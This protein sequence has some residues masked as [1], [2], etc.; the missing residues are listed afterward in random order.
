MNLRKPLILLAIAAIT[1]LAICHYWKPIPYN[2]KLVRIQAEQLLGPIDERITREPLEIQAVL[3]DYSGDKELTLKAWIAISKFPL[4]AQNIFSLY[5]SE[6]EF[7]S[8]LRSYGDAIIPVIQYFIDHEVQSLVVMKKTGT[9]IDTV[10]GCVK[11]IVDCV[12]AKSEPG[13]VKQ[14]QSP[15]LGPTERGWY[16]INFIKKEGHS[17]LGE[18]VVD[19]KTKGV[20]WV[21]TQRIMNA[22][23]ALVTSGIRVLETK[24]QLS[25]EITTRDAF[26][27]ILDVIPLVV[28]VKLLGAG[29]VVV[30]SGKSVSISAKVGEA[31][32]KVAKTSENELTLVSRTKLFG[33]RLI[34]KRAFFRQLGTYG[35]AVATAYVVIT[36]PSLV[37]SLLEELAELLGLNPL[38]V[39]FAGWL[40]IIT[41]A[42]YPFSWALIALAR[43]ILFGMSLI[44]KSGKQ[45]AKTVTSSSPDV[46]RIVP[47]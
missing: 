41:I 43:L 44:E 4:K 40:L 32:G 7:K 27:A 6:D 16:A 29:K 42:L 15:K 37:N 11:K 46:A 9:L 23:T 30:T 13:P 38:L 34:P 25:E 18:F 19:K 12:H 2:E 28:A 1:S 8:I 36:H 31:S 45:L 5:G 10:S 26:F 20:Q 35:A 14:K 17:F 47:S 21:Q 24:Y 39:Q 3:L 22:L 33:S